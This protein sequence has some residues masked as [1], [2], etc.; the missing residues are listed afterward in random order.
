M[1][2]TCVQLIWKLPIRLQ[3]SGRLPPMVRTRVY[4]ILKLRVEE[5]LSRRSSPWSG[6]AKPYMEITCSG[7][8]TVWTTVS[9]CPDDSVSLSRR[10]SQT[11]KIFSE[12]LEKSCRTVVRL[13]GLGSP[14][15]RCPYILLQ[16]PIL[17]LSL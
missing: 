12:I 7:R 1:V 8:A 9:H 4:Q 11:R 16:S 13:D 15:G 10:G 5:F 3:S 6:C 17:H 14:S 2:Q